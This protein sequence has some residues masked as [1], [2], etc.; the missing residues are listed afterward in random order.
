VIDLPTPPAHII[1][2]IKPQT[3][4]KLPQDLNLAPGSTFICIPIGLTS[5]CKKKAKV[6]S[7]KSVTYYVHAVDFTFTITV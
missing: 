6:G 4:I 5:Q 2:D 7:Q 1:V 3:G